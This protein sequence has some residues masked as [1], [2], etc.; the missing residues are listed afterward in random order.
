VT[1]VLG[2][3]MAIICN[4]LQICANETFSRCVDDECARYG[5]VWAMLRSFIHTLVGHTPYCSRRAG[6]DIGTTSVKVVLYDIDA[7]RCA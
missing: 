1:V 6:I 5:A 3:A 4:Y 2:V 7:C